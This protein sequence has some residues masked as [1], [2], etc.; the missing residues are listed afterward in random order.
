MLILKHCASLL[1]NSEVTWAPWVWPG[2]TTQEKDDF[3]AWVSV[4]L[5]NF[6]IHLGW[7]QLPPSQEEAEKMLRRGAQGTRP[8]APSWRLDWWLE[9]LKHSSPGSMA[10]FFH[11]PAQLLKKK[12]QI[13][14][15][16]SQ[17]SCLNSVWWK[18]WHAGASPHT[19]GL[20]K[21]AVRSSGILWPSC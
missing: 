4:Q 13:A 8:R 2:D 7:D 20:K 1:W 21:A 12:L 19:H 16:N 6:Q 10:H 15:F 3:R 18:S 11:P 9:V 14:A 5:W 17:I